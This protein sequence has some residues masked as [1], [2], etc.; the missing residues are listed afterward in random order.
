MLMFGN[1]VPGHKV[2]CCTCTRIPGEVGIVSTER[3]CDLQKISLSE[4]NIIDSN[5]DYRLKYSS[6]IYC[7]TSVQSIAMEADHSPAMV[8]LNLYIAGDGL[9]KSFKNNANTFW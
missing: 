8:L 3:R 7:R 6:M 4:W 1:P 9:A 2:A 5:I